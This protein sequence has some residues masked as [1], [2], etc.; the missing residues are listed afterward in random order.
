MD[1]SFAY[2]NYNRLLYELICQTTHV[3][4]IIII[5]KSVIRWRLYSIR[6][7]VY[8]V[9]YYTG[10]ILSELGQLTFLV[11]LY[12]SFNKLN[13]KRRKHGK[14]KHL[15]FARRILIIRKQR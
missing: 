4:T 3:G 8:V 14:K 11:E 12:L 15:L 2:A 6:F 7:D 5:V 13:G 1:V 10:S 9:A